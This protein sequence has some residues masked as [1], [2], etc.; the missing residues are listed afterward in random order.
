[1]YLSIKHHDMFR[2]LV[3]GFEVPFRNYVAEIVTTSFSTPETLQIALH[4]KF[5]SLSPSDPEFLRKTL[6]KGSQLENVKELYGKL[7]N[8][9]R[10]AIAE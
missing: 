2:T 4:H 9:K 3:M 6:G 1:M 8:A 7:L 5:T 10:N